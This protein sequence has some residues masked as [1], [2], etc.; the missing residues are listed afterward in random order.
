MTYHKVAKV[1]S[2]HASAAEVQAWIRRHGARLK[3]YLE[4]GYMVGVLDV[5]FVGM[6]GATGRMWVKRGARAV[7]PNKGSR[8]NAALHGIYFEDG[9][10]CVREYALADSATLI[11]FLKAVSAKYG[12]LIAYVDRSSIH[13][14]AETKEF[15]R[16]YRKLHPD[17]DIRLFLLPRGSPYLSVIEAF[18]IRLKDAVSKR[19]RSKSFDA[20]RRA[21]M[22]YARTVRLK[23]DLYEF[24]Y[25]DPRKH[26]LAS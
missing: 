1:Q 14:S 20:L 21:T 9:S 12:R 22:E 19:Y 6:D 8:Q 17:R 18:W 24:L 7:L 26:M 3:P 16:K 4:K 23:L 2:N 5:A 25:R 15:L 10:R 11:D 13:S